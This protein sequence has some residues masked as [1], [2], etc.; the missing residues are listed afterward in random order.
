MPDV[1]RYT[2]YPTTSE[3]V[4]ASQLK[5]T[6]CAAGGEPDPLGG[7]EPDPLDGGGGEPDPLGGGEPALLGLIPV[8]LILSVSWLPP[9]MLVSV[10][11]PLPVPVPVGANLSV[12]VFV[13]PAA[14]FVG[15]VKPEVEKPA[16]LSLAPAMVALCVP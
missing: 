2:L 9:K 7:G 13:L 11:V 10:I 12:K 6:E 8:P 15:K 4:L 3:E 5:A 16:P 1:A 14:S